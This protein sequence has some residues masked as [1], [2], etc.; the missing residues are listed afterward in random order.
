MSLSIEELEK[1]LQEAGM[2]AP[3]PRTSLFQLKYFVIGKEPTWQ[4]KMWK[5]L[6][7]IRSNMQGILEM[8]DQIEDIK[9]DMKIHELD[10]LS[11]ATVETEE[12]KKTRMEI[13]RRKWDRKKRNYQR[14]LNKLERN[15]NC[16]YEESEFLLGLFE[17]INKE[18]EL[19]CFDDEEAQSE[20]WNAKVKEEID[21][22][23]L[24][25][26]PTEFDLVKTAL[27]LPDDLPIKKQMILT[28]NNLRD[29]VNQM[30]EQEKSKLIKP[31]DK[32]IVE[33]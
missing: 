23:M 8:K 22:R 18:V 24:M 27:S 15:L 1:N 6:T 14:S 4:G 26:S 17:A 20:Y 11:I 19:K 5:C 33:G 10:F 2:K 16:A 12:P 9:D 13:Q 32:L 31:E 7:E 29:Q 25:Q 30:L 21:L 28:L 3:K